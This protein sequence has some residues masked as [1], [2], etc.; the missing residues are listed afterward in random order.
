MTEGKI[1]KHYREKQHLT[2]GELGQGICS[3]T[4]LSKIERGI[5]EYSPEII[6]LLCDRLQIDMAA[7]VE[8]FVQTQ[9]KLNDWHNAMVMQRTQEAEALKAQMERE[10]LRDLPDY[11][12]PYPLLLIRYHLYN[13]DLKPALQ[14]IREIQKAELPSPYV[15]NYFRH[16]QGIYYFLSGQFLDCIGVLT[17]IDESEYTEQEYY[18]HLALA[19]HS[20]HSSIIAYYYAEKALQYFRKTLNLIRIIDTET[21]MLIQLSVK[22]PHSFAIANQSYENL[23]KACELCGS[24]DRKYKLLHN[25]AYE[26][27]RRGLYDEAAE[28]FSQVMELV[29][30]PEH[31]F[32]LSVLDC[33]ITSCVGAKR[34]PV[35][36]L[37]ALTYQGLTLARER[38][39]SREINFNLLILSLKEDW[40]PYYRYIEEEAL[41]YFRS[42]GDTYTIERYERKLLSYYLKSGERDKALELSLSMISG[43]SSG[44]EEY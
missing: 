27:M 22:E 11:K 23:I 13:N 16:L 10:T 21:L 2:Q 43:M 26:H 12:I 6:D 29:G 19:Y 41:P 34:L 14:L 1:I 15:R 39:D 30:G 32:Y 4:H 35:S 38:K 18:Y 40:Q 36:G 42:N 24:A 28:G 25:L 37:L 7:E 31:P 5:T 9:R 8:R 20:I 17:E 44:L 3:V 33:Y